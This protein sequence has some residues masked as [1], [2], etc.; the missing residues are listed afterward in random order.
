M[1]TI[2]ALLTRRSVRHFTAEAVSP[3]DLET[4]LRAAMHAPSANNQ[5]PWQFIIITDNG[6]KSK[7]VEIHAYAKSLLEAPIGILVCGDLRLEK[8]KDYWVQDCAAATQNLLLAAH[9]LGLGGVWQGIYPRP[10]RVQA[11]S[12]L[13]RLPAEVI[14]FSLLSI[15]HPAEPLP[16]VERFLPERIHTNEW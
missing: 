11:V 13:L 10:A 2:Q 8:S 4:L 7:L 15:G 9:A 5:Q 12:E 16:K 1:D 14:P 3:E 6:L